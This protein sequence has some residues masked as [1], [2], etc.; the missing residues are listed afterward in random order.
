MSVAS[1]AQ[2]LQ[3]QGG[4][5]GG[6][7]VYTARISFAPNLVLDVGSDQVFQFNLINIPYNLQNVFLINASPSTAS[8]SFI[9][10]SIFNFSNNNNGTG[11]TAFR[12]NIHNGGTQTYTIASLSIIACVGVNYSYS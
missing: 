5:G 2:L 11:G 3:N 12:C 10:P 4:G 7:D 9:S 1:V 8:L 6:N